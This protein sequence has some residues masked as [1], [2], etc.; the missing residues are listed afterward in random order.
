[1]LKV[2]YPQINAA[3]PQ[4][5]VVVG[6]LLLDCNPDNP[7]ADASGNPKDCSPG[8]FLEGI[9]KAGG[10][11]YFDVVSYHSY[12]NFSFKLGLGGYGLGNWFSTWD[13]T[14]PAFIAKG[15]YL[16]ELLNRYHAGDKAL[17]ES[18][19]GLLCPTQ[20]DKSCERDDFIQTKAY[21]AA[22]A[23]A[24]GQ[25]EGLAAVIWYSITGWRATGLVDRQFQPL[26]VYHA[27]Q[28]S[29]QAIGGSVFVKKITQYIGVKG[30][31]FQRTNTR[32]WIL[33]SLDGKNHVLNLPQ[34]PEKIYDVLG[35]NLSAE[36]LLTVGLKPIYLEWPMP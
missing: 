9:L 10:Q 3:D 31:E 7:P 26:P 14:G 29:S 15:R 25:A 35:E 28:V 34:K 11:A 2:V 36:N 32:V 21:Y 24:D 8:R 12:D 17:I 5:R 33:W 20:D 4:A 27:I 16:R 30:Y 6:G 1:M 18:E 23:Y 13:T 19:V 22:Q